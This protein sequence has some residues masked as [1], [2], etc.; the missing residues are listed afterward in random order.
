M[1]DS[2]CMT[3]AYQQHKL[4]SCLAE[5]VLVFLKISWLILSR[6]LVPSM[7]YRVNILHWA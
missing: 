1:F 7:P 3:K 2:L 4:A 6:Y 5:A